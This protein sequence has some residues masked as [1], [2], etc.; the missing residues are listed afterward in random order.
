MTKDEAIDFPVLARI[1]FAIAVSEEYRRYK[2][3]TAVEWYL[4]LHPG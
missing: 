1:T 3:A 4:P 2:I